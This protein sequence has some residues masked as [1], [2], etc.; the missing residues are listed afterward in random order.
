MGPF[1][2]NEFF[3]LFQSPDEEEKIFY[4]KLIGSL[5]D[6]TLTK[7]CAQKESTS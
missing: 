3:S 7:V 4:T 5:E 6:Y 2:L 1:F